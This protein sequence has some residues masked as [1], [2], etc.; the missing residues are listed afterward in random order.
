M[1]VLTDRFDP[2]VDTGFGGQ[3]DKLPGD[4]YRTPD[5]RL[6][7]IEETRQYLEQQ[8][9]VNPKYLTY[10]ALRSRFNLNV[11]PVEDDSPTYLMPT[12]MGERFFR[13]TRQTPTEI[14]LYQDLYRSRRGP[15]V[16]EA[17]RLMDQ[18]LSQPGLGE[19]IN[20]W[21]GYEVYHEG[22]GII[23]SLVI[24][25]GRLIDNTVLNYENY[26]REKRRQKGY[27]EGSIRKWQRGEPELKPGPFESAAAFSYT[28]TASTASAIAFYL[29]ASLPFSYLLSRGFESMVEDSLNLDQ[30]VLTGRGRDLISRLNRIQLVGLKNAVVLEAGLIEHQMRTML[31]SFAVEQGLDYNKE[32]HLIQVNRE[33]HRLRQRLGLTREQELKWRLEP[34]FKHMQAYQPEDVGILVKFIN[35]QRR[36]S[37]NLYENIM[38]P[39]LRG[40]V[41]FAKEEA[42]VRMAEF[43][44]ALREQARILGSPITIKYTPQEGG[45]GKISVTGVYYEERVEQIAKRWDIISDYIPLNP[46]YWFPAVRETLGLPPV[47]SAETPMLADLLSFE[48]MAI[49]VKNV[50]ELSKNLLFP[51]QVDQHIRRVQN[52]RQSALEQLLEDFS[53]FVE[54]TAASLASQFQTKTRLY[55]RL[56][57][58]K[59]HK[60]GISKETIQA[61]FDRIVDTIAT[62][63]GETIPKPNQIRARNRKALED[64]LRRKQ[65]LER[66]MGRITDI[67]SPLQNLS[68]RISQYL[69]S[70]PLAQRITQT[71]EQLLSWPTQT[72]QPPRPG[73]I[74]R[75]WQNL[76][77]ALTDL[78][79]TL[80]DRLTALSHTLRQRSQKARG[81]VEREQRILGGSHLAQ[82][83]SF[84]EQAKRIL[85]EGRRKIEAVKAE[86]YRRIAERQAKQ[87]R[88]TED[89]SEQAESFKRR[90]ETTVRSVKRTFK[91]IR[92][93]LDVYKRAQGRINIQAVESVKEGLGLTSGSIQTNLGR[94]RQ[95]WEVAPAK[96]V[97]KWQE[98]DLLRTS[99]DGVRWLGKELLLT[100]RQAPRAA[101]LLGT[102]VLFNFQPKGTSLLVTDILTYMVLRSTFNAIKSIYL[103]FDRN[104]EKILRRLKKR[105]APLVAGLHR[106]VEAIKTFWQRGR[107]TVR[108]VLARTYSFISSGLDSLG[109]LAKHLR[110]SAWQLLRD[111]GR[112]ITYGWHRLGTFAQTVSH[113]IVD[114]I[115]NVPEYL[116]RAWQGLQGLA[117]YSL[118]A[119]Q[120]GLRWLGGQWQ[121]LGRWMGFVASRTL[122]TIRTIPTLLSRA[123]Q[124][125]AGWMGRTWEQ[126]RGLAGQSWRILTTTLGRTWQQVKQWTV[127]TWQS[128]SRFVKSLPGRLGRAWQDISY[129]ARQAWSGLVRQVGQLVQVVPATLK[130]A[131]QG[132]T[133]LAGLAWRN[134]TRIASSTW[135]NFTEFAYLTRQRLGQLLRGATENLKKSWLIL[136]RFAGRSWQAASQFVQS[137]PGRLERAWYSLVDWV[138]RVWQTTSQLVKNI[139]EK[140]SGLWQG[141]T[142]WIGRTWEKT[143]ALVGQAWQTTSQIVRNINEKLGRVWQSFTGWTGGVW[144]T[145]S[146]LAGQAWQITS[147]FA[148]NIPEMLGRAWQSF[149]GWAGGA[150][151]VARELAGQAWQTTS[152]LVR[153]IP[154][155]LNRVWQSFTG[156]IGRVGEGL[157]EFVG[158]TWRGAY[159]LVRSIPETLGRAWQSFAGWLG[160]AWEGT[161]AFVGQVWQSTSRLAKNVSETLGRAW[162]GFTG[163]IGGVWGRTRE[164]AEQTWRTASYLV[165]IIPRTLGRSWQTLSSWI[166]RLW[167]GTKTLAGQ[168]WR[169]TSQ[170]ARSVPELLGRTWDSLTGWIGGVWRGLGEF[171]GQARQVASQLV[172]SIPERLGRTWQTFTGWVAGVWEGA[173]ELVGQTWL[174]ASQLVKNIPERLGRAW[175]GLTSWVGGAWRSFTGWVGRAWQG[176]T[177]WVGGAW[178]GLSNLAE[179]TWLVT[180][181]LVRSVPE[182]LGRA[183]QGF[184]GWITKAWG[185]A[186]TLAGQAWQ[187]TSQF[188]KSIPGMLGRTWQGFTGWVGRTWVGVRRLAEQAWQTVSHSVRTIP[189]RLHRAW[190]GLTGWIGGIREE[191]SEFVEKTWQTTSQFV[192]SVPERISRTWQGITGRIG[193]LWEGLRSLA[194]QAWQTTSQ[195]IR[196]IPEALGR[197]WHGLTGWIGGAWAGI[198]E[199]AGQA[200][201]AI[202]QFVGSIP[203]RLSQA[204]QS[205]TGWLGGVWRGFNLLTRQAWQTASRFFRSIPE[206]LS[207]AWQ[208]LAGW[209]G[210]AWMG[211]REFTGQA[212]YATSQFV[213]SIPGRITRAWQEF[214]GWI[215]GTWEGIR[216]FA[217]QVWQTT[218]HFVRSIPGRIAGAWQGFTGWVKEL[219]SRGI[220]SAWKTGA[221]LTYGSVKTARFSLRILDEVIKNVAI[222]GW[223]AL[224]T[225]GRESLL[226]SLRILPTITGSVIKMGFQSLFGGLRIGI[227]AAKSLPRRIIASLGWIGQ[228]LGILWESS[229]ALAKQ[230]LIYAK[231]GWDMT[232]LLLREMPRMTMSGL[233]DSV[234]GLANILRRRDIPDMT[235]FDVPEQ[236]VKAERQAGIVEV[237]EQK[238]RRRKAGKKA[239]R[240]PTNVGGSGGGGRKGA[241]GFGPVPEPGRRKRPTRTSTTRPWYAEL[242]KIWQDFT[243]GVSSLYED[244]FGT[245]PV[246]DLEGAL[247]TAGTWLG[248]VESGLRT[249][250]DKVGQVSRYSFNLAK[251]WFGTISTSLRGIWGGFNQ[252]FHNLGIADKLENIRAH[253]VSRS[254]F[255][256]VLQKAGSV[257]EPLLKGA[258]GL[259]AEFDTSLRRVWSGLSQNV[260]E[261]NLT[262][263]LEHVRGIAA[264]WLNKI[265]EQRIGEKIRAKAESLLG[266]M[267]WLWSDVGPLFYLGTVKTGVE[268]LGRGIGQQLAKLRGLA[269]LGIDWLLD[270]VEPEYKKFKIMAWRWSRWLGREGSYVYSSLE[271]RTL[272]VMMSSLRASLGMRSLDEFLQWRSQRGAVTN[273]AEQIR[274][275]WSLMGEMRDMSVIQSKLS[276][277]LVK[278]VEASTRKLFSEQLVGNVLER[279]EEASRIY[280]R[281]QKEAIRAALHTKIKSGRWAQRTLWDVYKEKVNR[282]REISSHI[283]PGLLNLSAGFVATPI[284]S[285][286]K[287]LRQRWVKNVRGGLLLIG[288]WALVDK[289]V[290]KVFLSYKGAPL[291][292]QISAAAAARKGQ[293]NAFEIEFTGRPDPHLMLAA[294]SA[295]GALT[296]LLWPRIVGS[297]AQLYELSRRLFNPEGTNIGAFARHITSFEGNTASQ[298]TIENI[299]RT[300]KRMETLL[301]RTLQGAKTGG[302]N[303]GAAVIGAL[304]AG[305]LVETVAGIHAWW[306]NNLTRAKQGVALDPNRAAVGAR[307]ERLAIETLTKDGQPPSE[308]A[309]AA[310]VLQLVQHFY[311]EAPS[312]GEVVNIASQITTP[313]FQIAI[314]QQT[315][316]RPGVDWRGFIQGPIT[317]FGFSIQLMPTTGLGLSISL[318]LVYAN[319]VD[320]N[321]Y[322]YRHFIHQRTSPLTRSLI[323]LKSILDWSRLRKYSRPERFEEMPLYGGGVGEGLLYEPDSTFEV[324]LLGSGAV[325]ILQM[326]LDRLQKAKLGSQFLARELEYA[327]PALN[328]LSGLLRVVDSATSNLVAFPI[329]AVQKGVSSLWDALVTTTVANKRYVWLGSR[330]KLL[331]GM[332]DGLPLGRIAPFLGAYM[333]ASAVMDPDSSNIRTEA[334]PYSRFY[335]PGQQLGAFGLAGLWSILL[336]SSGATRTQEAILSAYASRFGSQGAAE[337]YNKIIQQRGLGSFISFEKFKERYM[338][339]IAAYRHTKTNVIASDEALRLMAMDA[340]IEKMKLSYTVTTQEGTRT[341]DLPPTGLSLKARVKSFALLYVATSLGLNLLA[342]ILPERT[343]YAIHKT[344]IIGSAFEFVT[345]VRPRE[346]AYTYYDEEMKQFYRTGFRKSQKQSGPL[347]TLVRLL[348][349]ASMG[350]WKSKDTVYADTPDPFFSILGGRFGWSFKKLGAVGYVQLAGAG[351]DVSASSFIGGGAKEYLHYLMSYYRSLQSLS[352]V[353]LGLQRKESP[354]KITGFVSMQDFRQAQ[355][356]RSLL[357]ALSLRQERIERL[358]YQHALALSAST[359]AEILTA[360]PEMWGTAPSLR[361]WYSFGGYLPYGTLLG[362]IVEYEAYRRPF[363]FISPITGAYWHTGFSYREVANTKEYLSDILDDV[364]FINKQEN[365]RGLDVPLHS[366]PLSQVF[367]GIGLIAYAIFY[368][369]L[370]VGGTNFVYSLTALNDSIKPKTQGNIVTYPHQMHLS[371]LPDDSDRWHIRQNN[372]YRSTINREELVRINLPVAGYTDDQIRDVR[373]EYLQRVNN[374]FDIKNKGG[375]FHNVIKTLTTADPTAINTLNIT[376]LAK[377]NAAQF[378]LILRDSPQIQGFKNVNFGSLFFHGVINEAGVWELGEK[379]ALFNQ[380]LQEHFVRF[381]TSLKDFAL[382]QEFSRIGAGKP[383]AVAREMRRQA[384]LAAA[385]RLGMPLKSFLSHY[386]SGGVSSRAYDSLTMLDSILYETGGKTPTESLI[387]RGLQTVWS[388]ARF[389]FFYLSTGK[390]LI[391]ISQ[392]L[393]ALV[394]SEGRDRYAAKT[395]SEASLAAGGVFVAQ[396]LAYAIIPGQKTW[397]G[398]LATMFAVMGGL[399]GLHNYKR[400]QQGR[401]LDDLSTNI[402][403]GSANIAQALAKSATANLTSKIATVGILGGIG[404]FM[405]GWRSSLLTAA[406]AALALHGGTYRTIEKHIIEPGLAWAISER[407]KSTFNQYFIDTFLPQT[408]LLAEMMAATEPSKFS[409]FVNRRWYA[410][411]LLARHKMKLRSSLGDEGVA[412]E[413]LP[414]ELLGSLPPGFL[415]E[416]GLDRFTT[417]EDRIFSKFN[418]YRNYVSRSQ[419]MALRARQDFITRT[420]HQGLM[421]R[422]VEPASAFAKLVAGRAPILATALLSNRPSALFSWSTSLALVNLQTELEQNLSREAIGFFYTKRDYVERY[423][424]LKALRLGHKLSLPLRLFLPKGAATILGVR[425]ASTLVDHFGWY[426]EEAEDQYEKAKIKPLPVTDYGAL[427]R[428]ISVKSVIDPLL[429]RIGGSLTRFGKT[430]ITNITSRGGGT[431]MWKPWVT[432]LWKMYV[433]ADEVHESIWPSVGKALR[434]LKAWSKKPGS[435]G[436]SR[437]GKGLINLVDDLGHSLPNLLGRTGSFLQNLGSSRWIAIGMLATSAAALVTG[438]FDKQRRDSTLR[439]ILSVGGGIAAWQLQS[440]LTRRYGWYER[441]LGRGMVGGGIRLAILLGAL[442]AGGS[443]FVDNLDS[444]LPSWNL[445]GTL[446]IGIGGGLVAYGAYSTLKSVG[447]YAWHRALERLSPYRRARIVAATRAQQQWLARTG[448]HLKQGL[449]RQVLE[450]S[451]WANRVLLKD[452]GSTVGY[453]ISTLQY[454]G[455]AVDLLKSEQIS[456]QTAQSLTTLLTLSRSLTSAILGQSLFGPLG[457]FVGEVGSELRAENDSTYAARLVRQA[458][459]TGVSPLA[460]GAQQIRR[461]VLS[462]YAA[463]AFGSGVLDPIRSRMAAKLLSSGHWSGRM[464]GRIMSP[465]VGTGF[466]AWMRRQ[467]ITTSTPLLQSAPRPI[468]LLPPARTPPPTQLITQADEVI[469]S[470]PL[471]LNPRLALPQSQQPIGLL[472]P[473]RTTAPAFVSNVDDVVKPIGLLPPARSTPPP[474]PPFP[475]HKALSS[476]K[477]IRGSSLSGGKIAPLIDYGIA[478]GV[479]ASG[480]Y[481]FGTAQDKYQR[482]K[483]IRRMSGAVGQMVG[484][485]L[486]TTLGIIAGATAGGLTAASG[487]GALAAATA[488]FIAVKTGVMLLTEHLFNLGADFYLSRLAPPDQRVEARY[489]LL[490]SDEEKW[491]QESRKRAEEAHI[492]RLKNLQEYRRR[493]EQA[494]FKPGIRTEDGR[495]I[496]P[497]PDPGVT[498]RARQRTER[499]KRIYKAS[500]YLNVTSHAEIKLTPHI[501]LT[502]IGIRIDPQ[503]RSLAQSR[504][505]E[506]LRQSGKEFSYHVKGYEHSRRG[507]FVIADIQNHLK[508]SLS[509]TL[510]REG[511]ATVDPALAKYQPETYE[512]YRRLQEK[513]KPRREEHLKN[514][515]KQRQTDQEKNSNTLGSLLNFMLGITPAEAAVPTS[516]LYKDW[517]QE[518]KAT[519]STFTPDTRR[520]PTATEEKDH[521]NPLQKLWDWVSTSLK[522][523]ARSIGQTLGGFFR[524]EERTRQSVPQLEKLNQEYGMSVRDVIQ[525]RLLQMMGISRQSNLQGQYGPGLNALKNYL[526]TYAPE[527]FNEN[528]RKGRAAILLA[529]YIGG[530]EITGE[531]NRA[532]KDPSVLWKYRGGSGNAMQGFAQIHTGYFGKNKRGDGYVDLDNPAEYAKFVGRM[533]HGERRLP[534]GARFFDLNKF[535]SFL[536]TKPSEEQ[537]IKYLQREMPFNRREANWEG[538]VGRG[539]RRLLHETDIAAQINRWYYTPPSPTEQRSLKAPDIRQLMSLTNMGAQSGTFK[540]EGGAVS[541]YDV[542]RAGLNAGVKGIYFTSPYGPRGGRIHH[543]IDV[544]SI[545]G[546]SAI[547]TS[548]QVRVSQVLRSGFNDGGYG[549]SI[550]VALP[551]GKRLFIAHLRNPVPYKVGDVL[552]PGALLGLEGNTGRS[553]GPHYHIEV[554]SSRGERLP[555][556]NYYHYLKNLYILRGRG[557]FPSTLP[558]SPTSLTGGGVKPG[559]YFGKG[560][561]RYLESFL[562]DQAS[563][564]LLA[565]TIENYNKSLPEEVRRRALALE[566]QGKDPNNFVEPAGLTHH[567]TKPKRSENPRNLKPSTAT[568]SQQ[569]KTP[570]PQPA[571]TIHRLQS[572]H[573]PRTSQALAQYDLAGTILGASVNL[574]DAV[575]QSAQEPEPQVKITFTKPP[576]P[577]AADLPPP[578][579]AKPELNALGQLTVNF[580][581]GKPP[582]EYSPDPT[583]S[584]LT[585]L[586]V[587]EAYFA[588]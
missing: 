368:P 432:T 345:N 464:L 83:E 51:N 144:R 420:I 573:N 112:L 392:S 394:A 293:D 547:Y 405:G 491:W 385:E 399:M 139:P 17:I 412:E 387:G 330:N 54:N 471:T 235:D 313:I 39:L 226:T 530:G 469:K 243:S 188:V 307:L 419:M 186:K 335:D 76:D 572:S 540:I 95:A 41:S 14:T 208:G 180:S 115:S 86:K 6:K 190:Q 358:R 574:F 581:D 147:R 498:T 189:E 159:R 440:Y 486:G 50:V 242:V 497:H 280:E 66:F 310:A 131:W 543:G 299:L 271:A 502:P 160:G 263:K 565:Q 254:G 55:Q 240:K 404:Y 302:F 239:S 287:Y 320:L 503:L 10:A 580:D 215:G 283:L 489:A 536:D 213:R 145:V 111:T 146:G 15:D 349:M 78:A 290:D 555:T 554:R 323:R 33:Y 451:A 20:R 90:I 222:K 288:T 319:R 329:Q 258:E 260:Q 121:T 524:R 267:S 348:Q 521:R 18:K 493:Q 124:G 529:L 187:V 414:S 413:I 522:N 382:S 361:P 116:S 270:R 31:R 492:R 49:W 249:V 62:S 561:Q 248:E 170:L 12:Q 375:V 184:T 552:P 206:T 314:T 250:G 286:A 418:P 363:Q 406:L 183:W 370:L 125:L 550:E 143:K 360:L 583:N 507:T 384:L 56:L 337:M 167:E 548:S 42:D 443:L 328:F 233:A 455:G 32:R 171:V 579:N 292:T 576:Q 102:L 276:S 169:A 168:A 44:S 473:A 454:L 43:E 386:G 467:P 339:A 19:Q 36:L 460:L 176:L 459:L 505:E 359:K 152:Q 80:A 532:A 109:A 478:A 164:L 379:A 269:D 79:D 101:A 210:R 255:G 457:A 528:T 407:Q 586:S 97:Q 123:W 22:M 296:G 417:G 59:L 63:I 549:N 281:A 218:S 150:W 203:E 344:P 479:F 69:V 23:G 205:L 261:L 318:P 289:L 517:Q 153:N 477:G 501:I 60:I 481:I 584:L 362:Q 253:L 166:G 422:P 562:P 181:Q 324:A 456:M 194:G 105:L 424:E 256:D 569:T 500:S 447:V 5:G 410:M 426:E 224:L 513:A 7:T 388:T 446:G 229:L 45:L 103:S 409:P 29:G 470:V 325:S 154:E 327:K 373:K 587:A 546:A 158:Q 439:A 487:P 84:Q 429:G 506:F 193:E 444:F 450:A 425:L 393:G 99:L 88:I 274:L 237:Y 220:E 452:L 545:G 75:I 559:E 228:Q 275:I 291:S 156:W 284:E 342:Q 223:N 518:N 340:L 52:Y 165:G 264:G 279:A 278:N 570:R 519:I 326:G 465:K 162:Q 134:L 490:M 252:T 120:Q 244:L 26:Q 331:R 98:R 27:Y 94:I 175:Q 499:R 198:R 108:Q 433:G 204:W 525:E 16:P 13:D 110:A 268:E 434:N 251:A 295:T 322:Y 231:V 37:Q 371:F 207:K 435:R 3:I 85:E 28:M 316:I 202:S 343:L 453:S 117:R 504:T 488:T 496:L 57:R 285:H 142:D 163:W 526:T 1:Q 442:A 87:A 463:V 129:L 436:L 377:K 401:W 192:R 81:V 30:I 538:I 157:R 214:T 236:L 70:S 216:S 306:H 578:V 544:A 390:E 520:K 219:V 563:R 468:G 564:A 277:Q 298:R 333:L 534:A 346:S 312:M 380:E 449:S 179:Q 484:A 568:K 11:G 350:L 369:S 137:L 355:G 25:L 560:W 408:S 221:A 92:K 173:K 321:T 381:Y 303:F 238:S 77:Y 556:H 265:K 437:L 246:I 4:I 341:F 300:S 551:D 461:D 182:R 367:S 338:Q 177:S 191:V 483:G 309:K 151:R 132:L 107:Q 541:V 577:P 352:D 353:F 567:D 273:L 364:K 566:A 495:T 2:Y 411:T 427:F 196:S 571:T 334:S 514:L 200:R 149:A 389:S 448:A 476:G 24:S 458:D 397:F 575:N 74:Q 588:A 304:L 336:H 135:Q 234:S 585:N 416:V 9:I 195:L 34:E 201:Q 508:E 126:V 438:G 247:R 48:N 294:M 72:Q 21:L 174:A 391:S 128:T 136:K 372:L 472:P 68:V 510:I 266:R 475:V 259:F 230:S 8:G 35:W 297:E 138:G 53:F 308:Y 423:K 199:L 374:L 282:I 582:G 148:R 96:A 65:R 474:R 272:D 347:G 130:T 527:Y 441:L 197:T 161:K 533:L 509:E 245:S 89:I 305:Q 100:V 82:R 398:S 262:Q 73:R 91:E 462:V 553:F 400:S 356:S 217:G 512:Y 227:E 535:I 113:K 516:S 64:Y 378:A 466:F 396:R 402:I 225:W 523:L 47:R 357:T 558:T 428:S 241:R 431:P 106:S 211:I 212:W 542:V 539:A 155:R 511:I 71:L 317:R 515:Q 209:A 537:I 61:G 232:G 430:L 140:L 67:V 46:L 58:A 332:A 403:E 178:R 485:F 311:R 482:A 122:G 365:A 133:T 38:M 172:R 531:L 119:A 557:N 118:R 415:T 185:T 114:A 301:F 395:L 376:E 445:L 494:R 127:T 40:A 366:I 480:A 104:K 257:L 315:Q 141:F 383:E 421:R 93:K 351:M 354:A